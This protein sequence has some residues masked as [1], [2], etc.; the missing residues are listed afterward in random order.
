MRYVLLG[1]ALAALAAC[2][3]PPQL[4]VFGQV[5]NFTLTAQTGEAFQGKS[6]AGKIWVADFIF[7][8]C[9]DSCPRMSSGMH[10]IEKQTADLPDLK[11]VSFTIDPEHDTP[12]V[13]TEYAGRFHADPGRWYFLTGPAPE[14]HN[15]NRNAFKLGDVNGALMHS[16]RFVLV[17]RRGWIRGYYDTEEGQSL[18]PLI[19]DIR[20]LAKVHS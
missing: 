3:R 8:R 7:T 19:R 2:S 17:D 1:A 12:P 5:P 16:T 20:R 18:D 15:L 10:W 14:L 4:P 9:V 6:L 13:L 11:L